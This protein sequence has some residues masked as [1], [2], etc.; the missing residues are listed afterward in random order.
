MT[1]FQLR[2]RPSSHHSPFLILAYCYSFCVGIIMAHRDT[3][4]SDPSF[5]LDY[6]SNF[7]MNQIAMA[8]SSRAISVK[9][10]TLFV[11]AILIAL[12]TRTKSLPLIPVTSIFWIKCS[13]HYQLLITPILRI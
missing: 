11:A 10:T 13:S 8:T 3:L 12:D 4:P 7:R 2:F 1:F 6:L 9:T 5:Q